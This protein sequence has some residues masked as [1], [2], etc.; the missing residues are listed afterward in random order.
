MIDDFPC[1]SWL[2]PTC[3]VA[4]EQRLPGLSGYAQRAHGFS[5]LVRAQPC[6]DADMSAACSP[7]R[8]YPPREVRAPTNSSRSREH[9]ACSVVMYFVFV[10]CS[11]PPVSPLVL[12]MCLPRC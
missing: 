9:A 2:V 11:N 3:A 1:L 12:D 6:V 8:V 7:P 10:L 4:C 5:Q